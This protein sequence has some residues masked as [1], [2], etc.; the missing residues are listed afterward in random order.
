[1][2]LGGGGPQRVGTVEVGKARGVLAQW[3]SR[4]VGGRVSN[5]G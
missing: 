5:V 4:A 3:P 1:M 2:L